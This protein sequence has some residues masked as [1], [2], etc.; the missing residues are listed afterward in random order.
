[1][2]QISATWGAGAMLG[3]GRQDGKW[4][5]E[6]KRGST[7][8]QEKNKGLLLKEVVGWNKTMRKCAHLMIKK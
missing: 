3:E 7:A 5:E 2:T 4:G 8:T 6:G 1:M